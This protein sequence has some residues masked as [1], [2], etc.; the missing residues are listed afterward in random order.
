[1]YEFIPPNSELNESVELV[2]KTA[3]LLTEQEWADLA[4]MVGHYKNS[5]TWVLRERDDDVPGH[6]QDLRRRRLLADRIMNA[7]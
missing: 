7:V 4:V 3:M 2:T 5:T 1:M 6:I